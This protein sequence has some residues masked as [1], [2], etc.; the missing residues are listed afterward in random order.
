M[1][2]INKRGDTVDEM[3][4]LLDTELTWYEEEIKE[5]RP[6]PAREAMTARAMRVREQK[7]MY[8]ELYNQTFNLHQFGFASEGIEDAQ[9]TLSALKSAKKELMMKTVKIQDID[10]CTFLI[11]F[12]SLLF[13]Y[14]NLMPRKLTWDLKLSLTCLLI[15]N[16]IRNLMWSRSSTCLQHLQDMLHNQLPQSSEV[17]SFSQINFPNPRNS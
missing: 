7:R 6:G 12:R 16:L 9:E 4:K 5:I 2:R 8:E 1:G 13:L 3:I 17:S 14:R 10:A 11:P 15:C